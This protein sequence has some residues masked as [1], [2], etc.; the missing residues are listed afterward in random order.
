MVVAWGGLIRVNP[1]GVL[2]RSPVVLG[3]ALEAGEVGLTAEQAEGYQGLNSAGN[4]CRTPR[5]LRGSSA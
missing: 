2:E 1:R 5:G 3:P 4:G